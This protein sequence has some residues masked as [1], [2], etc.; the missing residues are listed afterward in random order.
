MLFYTGMF[1][2]LIHNNME[3]QKVI[4]QKNKKYL[5]IIISLLVLL[6]FWFFIISLIWKYNLRNGELTF[7]TQKN[8]NI[9][10]SKNIESEEFIEWKVQDIPDNY[11]DSLSDEEKNIPEDLLY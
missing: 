6:L 9:Q 3:Q 8:N 4:S 1:L 2:L 10:W 7:E 5:D 11:F